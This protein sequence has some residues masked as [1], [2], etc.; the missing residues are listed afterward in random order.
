MDDD[1]QGEFRRSESALRAER[2][3]PF[4]D[5]CGPLGPMI[6]ISDDM[7]KALKDEFE[8]TGANLTL[9]CKGI[10][11]EAGTIRKATV[12]NWRV[13]RTTKT[14]KRHWDQ[15][16]AALNALPDQN[17]NAIMRL[18][19]AAEKQDGYSS[20]KAPRFE[21][22]ANLLIPQVDCPLPSKDELKDKMIIPT[23][24]DT[25]LPEQKAWVVTRSLNAHQCKYPDIYRTIDRD[26]YEHLH[27]ELDRTRIAPRALLQLFDSAPDDLSSQRIGEWFRLVTRSAEHRFLNWVIEAYALLPD[28]TEKSLFTEAK[29]DLRD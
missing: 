19:K 8:R 14:R 25:Q 24:H 27:A 9:L 29:G 6:L 28:A 15:V 20:P 18:T 16:M 21:R 4:A 7:R 11:R 26:T 1:E 22:R 23:L 17:S 5:K 3:V 13:G 12:S 2:R 10:S